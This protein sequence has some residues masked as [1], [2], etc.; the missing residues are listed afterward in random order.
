MAFD[1]LS[2]R[3]KE[4]LE[5]SIRSRQQ[6][7]V[8]L[9]AV[10]ERRQYSYQL[11]DQISLPTLFGEA[12]LR[13]RRYPNGLVT[14][15]CIPLVAMDLEG[16]NGIIHLTQ[17]LLLPPRYLTVTDLIVRQPQLSK[18]AAAIIQGQLTNPLREKSTVT[19]FAPINKAWD[20]LAESFVKDLLADI[21]A[22]QDLLKYHIIDDIWCHTAATGTH[23]I[24][25]INHKPLEITCNISETIVGGARLLDDGQFTGNGVVYSVDKVLL[26][27]KVLPLTTVAENLGLNTFLELLNQTGLI[28]NLQ[29]RGAFTLFA[30]TDEAFAELQ[31]YIF[32][33][34]ANNPGFERRILEMH[35]ALGS[36]LSGSLVD[37]LVLS[38]VAEES[39]LYV[40][41][42]R[43]RLSVGLAIVTDPDHEAR[44]GVL[45]IID[46]VL[47]PTQ[48]TVGTL[49]L[50]QSNVSIFT[51]LLN[52]T[53]S[54]LLEVLDD[55]NTITTL[56][57]PEDSSFEY[58]ASGLIERLQAEPEILEM[59]L[60]NH[61]VSDLVI[62]GGLE[63][64]LFYQYNTWNDRF[65]T[66][67]EEESGSLTVANQ[68][69]V[70]EKDIAARN[71]VIHKISRLI[72]F[73]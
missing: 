34:S 27:Q 65:I 30:P 39:F 61:F 22:L 2:I 73:S 67:R 48:N 4:E 37:G 36:H 33:Q 12:A 35:I 52:S 69:E 23:T 41:L 21:S 38:G 51:S 25:S 55:P 16:N 31:P 24:H 14:V 8:L 72:Q 60:K 17:S 18:T 32:N 63:P 46:R 20:I 42:H 56:F 62:S 13:F 66:I 50:S 53:N 11:Q 44:N 29:S 45:H 58:L 19:V 49:L 70:T 40:K 15:N 59:I 43:K 54:S 64:L 71:G 26:P 9:Y 57:V 6:P 47:L 3:G 1:N 68:A 10:V 5:E 28:E 7:P